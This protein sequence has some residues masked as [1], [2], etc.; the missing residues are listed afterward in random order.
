V[1]GR[2]CTRPADVVGGRYCEDCAVAKVSAKGAG[3]R[4]YAVDPERARLLWA[5]SEELVR[6]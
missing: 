5:K 4:P 2:D 3:V 6:D 1:G